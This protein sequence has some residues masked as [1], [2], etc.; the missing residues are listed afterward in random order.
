MFELSSFFSNKKKLESHK[1]VFFIYLGFLS[2]TFTNHRTAG[3]GEGHFFNFSLPL[4]PA[5]QT[6]RPLTEDYCREL[7]STHS[8]QPDS[9]RVPLVSERKPITTKLRAH[10]YVKVIIPSENT[11]INMMYTQLKIAWKSFVDP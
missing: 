10:K 1:R 7:T 2:Q 5:S 3:E 11:K 4:P 9:N 8:R 6:L